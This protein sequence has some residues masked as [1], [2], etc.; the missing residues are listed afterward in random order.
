MSSVE[1]AL[2]HK[3]ATKDVRTKDL[4]G[5]ASTMEFTEA[6]VASMKELAGN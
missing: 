2:I 3:L 6:V 1:K 5:T 4:G